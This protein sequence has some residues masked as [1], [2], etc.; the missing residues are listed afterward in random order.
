MDARVLQSATRYDGAAY[1]TGYVVECCLKTLVLFS[2]RNK[3]TWKGSKGHDFIFLNSEVLKFAIQ[4]PKA[5]N[6]VPRMTSGHSLYDKTSG[7]KVS[8]RYRAPGS[9]SEADTKSWLDEATEVYKSTI[10]L[11]RRNGDL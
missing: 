7:W 6:Y 8:L 1:L 9:I 2:N 5:A 3:P 4:T 10:V 11:M